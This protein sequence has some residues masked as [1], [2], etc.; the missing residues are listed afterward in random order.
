LIRELDALLSAHPFA[1]RRITALS[2]AFWPNRGW[3]F[4]PAHKKSRAPE[5]RAPSGNATSEIG[6]NGPAFGNLDGLFAENK[7]AA[8]SQPTGGRRA[9]CYDDTPAVGSLG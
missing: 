7:T 6:G 4:E 2:G 5:S 9:M 8:E 1:S 3:P